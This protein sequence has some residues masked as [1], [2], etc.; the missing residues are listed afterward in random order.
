[1]PLQVRLGGLQ[2][3]QLALGFSPA[4]EALLSLHVLTDPGHHPVQTPWVINA[5]RRMDPWLKEEAQA[6]RFLY[7]RPIA[8][9][10][11]PAALEEGR[12][13]D[14]EILALR[15]APDAYIEEAQ[16]VAG[17]WV[18]EAARRGEKLEAVL[19]RSVEA[20]EQLR[21]DPEASHRR[22]VRFLR[23]Y[24][25]VCLAP[26][27]AEIEGVLR[28]DIEHR[29]RLLARKGPLALVRDLWPDAFAMTTAEGVV[30]PSEGCR[31]AFHAGEDG[32]LILVPTYFAWPHILVERGDPVTV[33]YPALEVR[34]EGQAPVPPK[35]TLQTLQ[36]LADLTRLQIIQLLGRRARTTG[37]LAGVIGV[38]E[39]AISK[40]LKVLL[41]AGLVQP[42]RSGYYVFYHLSRE[43]V[44][45]LSGALSRLVEPEP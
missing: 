2:P 18:E 30:V 15:R 8:T 13:F 14:G 16:A 22:F 7:Q 25:E 38:S 40:H 11:R 36:A 17:W 28:Q 42:R 1:V 21:S 37:E 29:E 20:I 19:P 12:T 41:E 45:G 10:W 6:F 3:H 43:S 26:G 9:F 34:R 4:H 23:R 5:R 35:E 32:Q 39:S 27:W 33:T 31:A 44:A 24:W